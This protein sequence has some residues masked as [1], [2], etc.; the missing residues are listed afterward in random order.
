MSVGEAEGK[1]S[2]ESEIEGGGS[3][4]KREPKP[5]K[6]GGDEG[7]KREKAKIKDELETPYSDESGNRSEAADS[8]RMFDSETPNQLKAMRREGQR[9]R[10]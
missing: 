1:S 10:H 8:V 6:H 4:R 7:N 9:K 5:S 3:N 2:E